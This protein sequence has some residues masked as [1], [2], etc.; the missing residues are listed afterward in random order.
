MDP[1]MH[2][3]FIVSKNAISEFICCNS[4]KKK[5]SRAE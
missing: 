5:K 3:K 2:L 1:N 4:P